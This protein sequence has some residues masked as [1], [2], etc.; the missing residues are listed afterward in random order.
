[1]LKSKR[2]DLYKIVLAFSALSIKRG[3]IT[4]LAST[5]IG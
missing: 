5:A 4:V 1:M 2:F 3:S